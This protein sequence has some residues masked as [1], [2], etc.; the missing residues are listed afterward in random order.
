[1][2][3][4]KFCFAQGQHAE[5]VAFLNSVYDAI[6]DLRTDNDGNCRWPEIVNIQRAIGQKA[7]DL[8]AVPPQQRRR[9]SDVVR[10]LHRA[11]DGVKR[12]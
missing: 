6:G 7:A 9:I 4:P 3:D 8:A 2:T 1:M 5:V 12:P 11:D 10:R